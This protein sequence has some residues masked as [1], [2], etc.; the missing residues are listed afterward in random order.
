MSPGDL[1]IVRDPMCF[2]AEE[3]RGA[4]AIYLG[5][6]KTRTMFNERRKTFA[7][8][9]GG[10]VKILSTGFYYSVEVVNYLN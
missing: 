4:Y 9:I 6:I 3:W 8:L 1:V 5:E 2:F 10:E 7:F